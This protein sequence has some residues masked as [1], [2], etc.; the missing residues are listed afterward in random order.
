MQ[1]VGRTWNGG[2]YRYGFNGK[3]N[4]NDVKGEGNQQ[5][6]GMRI[7]DP[8]LGKFLSVDPLTKEYPWNSTYAFAENDVIRCIDL[9]GA[10]KLPAMDQYK[11]N[12]SWG[13]FDRLKA[14][15]NVAGK[16]YNGAVAGSWNSGVDFF[17]SLGKGTLGKDLKTEGQQVI[18]NIKKEAVDAYNYHSKPLSKQFSDFGKYLIDPERTEDAIMFFGI[19]KVAAGKGNLLKME[20]AATTKAAKY[21]SGTFVIGPK[22]L[23]KVTTHLKNLGFLEEAGN[24]IMLERLGKIVKG[25]LKP[26]QT[27]I[28][29]ARHELRESEFMKKGMNLDEAHQTT[30]KEQ[31][32]LNNTSEKQLYTKEALDASNKQWERE[33]KNK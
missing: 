24:Q 1:M 12:G 8:R 14:I 17:T 32:M 4:D 5:D 16:I 25:E 29:F 28:N 19:G 7:Y 22:T 13:W 11:Y 31:R 30:L 20:T 2:T 21:M 6:Y 18:N 9:D 3:E 27:D 23:E 33:T 15:P 26:T 10:E